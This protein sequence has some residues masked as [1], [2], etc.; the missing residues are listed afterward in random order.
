MANGSKARNVIEERLGFLFICLFVCCCCF[1]IIY[2]GIVKLI[3]LTNDWLKY[4]LMEYWHFRV[5]TVCHPSFSF[6]NRCLLTLKRYVLKSFY[7][8]CTHDCRQ[9]TFIVTSNNL[10]VFLLTVSQ[11]IIYSD[12]FDAKVPFLVRVLLFEFDYCFF[13]EFRL[14]YRISGFFRMHP[15]SVMFAR[16]SESCNAIGLMWPILAN[17]VD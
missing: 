9:L 12:D 11:F 7:W 10:T 13:E 8:P 6:K 14:C 15:F 17:K 16:V 3:C 4:C 5:H 2:K 1:C